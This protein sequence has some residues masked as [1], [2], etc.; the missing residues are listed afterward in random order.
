MFKHFGSLLEMMQ[1]FPDE[2]SCID[3]LTE[4]RWRNGAACPHCGSTKVY[5]FSDKRTHK[6]GDCRKRFSIKVGTIF[7]DSKIPLRTWFVAVYLI[8]AHKKGISSLQLSRDLDVTQKTAWFMLHR[9]REAS[10]SKSFNAPL[11]NKVEVDETYVGGKERNKHANKRTPGQQGRSTVKKTAAVALIERGG[12]VRV[13]QVKDVS[14][15]TLRKLIIDNVALGAVVLT[16]EF[17]AYQGLQ[18]FFN[19]KRVN[20]GSGEYVTGDAHTN[21]AE[22]FFS[23][24]KRGVIGIYHQVSR[25]HMHRY[26]DEFAFRYNLRKAD[27][28]Q[29]FVSLLENSG[30][31]LTYSQL[32]ANDG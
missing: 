32:I 4:I 25:K 2:Q 18:S 17:T 22:G 19:H 7:E 10:R 14:T 28:G 24:F 1:T 5:H 16:D 13:F 29:P 31:R 11:K 9:L 26:L 6:C 20:H 23:L 21:T 3:H 12:T 27:D 30:G 8:T 15:P